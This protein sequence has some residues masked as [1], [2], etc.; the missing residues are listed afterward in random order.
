MHDKHDFVSSQANPYHPLVRRQIM[1]TASVLRFALAVA[2]LLSLVIVASAGGGN[3]ITVKSFPDFAV[4]GKPLNLTFRVFVPSQDPPGK[5]Q[6]LVRASSAN[7]A[8]ARVEA[9]PGAVPG[10]YRATLSLTE[11][12]DWSI[13]IDAQGTSKLPVL[14]VIA[15]GAPEPPPLPLE[16]RGLRLFVS[17]GCNGCH[18]RGDEVEGSG[19]GPDLTGRRF[20]PEYLRKFLADPSITPV[21][22]VVCSRNRCGSPYEMPNLHLNKAE[23]AALV[24]FINK[25]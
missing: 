22:D 19:Y 16:T 14:P 8:V 18:Y 10:E 17:K 24:A 25:K 7:G 12:G 2:A 1:K 3:L 20:A 13:V 5:L 11:P 23:I 9:K 6:P 21:P 4:A 15:P